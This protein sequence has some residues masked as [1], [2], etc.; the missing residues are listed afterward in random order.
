[1]EPEKKPEVQTVTPGVASIKVEVPSPT[2]MMR[3]YFSS[4]HL[5][6][7]QHF[8][9][10]AKEIENQAGE[11]PRFDIKHR[12]NVTGAVLS[13]VAFLEAAVNE[14]FKD[15]VDE[16]ESYISAVGADSRKL[17]KAF[18]DLTEERNRSPFSILDKYQIVLTFC[19]K[20][21]FITGAQPYQDADLAIKLR[22][23]LMHYKPESYGGETQHKFFRQL[24][25]KFSD[26]PLLASSGNPYFPDKCLGSPCAKWTIQAVKA[27]A[28]AF[29][30]SLGLVPHY[31]RVKF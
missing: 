20:E 21:Q 16:H 6:A 4:Y 27:L 13:A 17:I 7:S 10:C 23:E 12:A 26:N 14:L 29:F 22:N 11:K 30:Q 24:P 3:V 18:W 2:V 25:S 31:Q 5:W 9:R 1:M 19:R 8:A 28:D 15:V